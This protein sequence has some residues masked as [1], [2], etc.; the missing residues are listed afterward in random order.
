MWC[1]ITIWNI[2][3]CMWSCIWTTQI[4]KIVI[5]S[6][7]SNNDGFLKP[8][9][10][11]I[12]LQVEQFPCWSEQPSPVDI[13]R[14][15]EKSNHLIGEYHSIF[16]LKLEFLHF[17]WQSNYWFSSV[18]GR[19]HWFFRRNRSQSPIFKFFTVKL[20]ISIFLNFSPF[21]KFW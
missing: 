5:H 10:D 15:P 9:T 19:R 12:I 11:I 18:E 21:L 1:L 2:S 20:N 3:C 4:V 7:E 14:I 8:L 6:T 16:W 13:L 17:R